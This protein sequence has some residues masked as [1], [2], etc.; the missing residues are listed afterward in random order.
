MTNSGSIAGGAGGAISAGLQGGVGGVGV[1]NLVGG[2]IG[3]LSVA[4]GGTIQ[5]GKGVDPGSGGAAIVNAGAITAITDAG[6]IDGGAGGQAG[7]G[8]VGIAN[9]GGASIGSLTINSGGAVQG[10]DGGF[11]E[12]GGSGIT[13]AGA[14]GSLVVRSGGTDRWWICRTRRR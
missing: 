8:G 2:S 10:G 11:G 1:S 14:L 4:A 3:H 9:G 6:Q 5:G 12:S 13:N 7:I